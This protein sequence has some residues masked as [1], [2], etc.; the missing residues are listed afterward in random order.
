MHSQNKGT[1]ILKIRNLKKESLD[2]EVEGKWYRLTGQLAQDGF[3]ASKT[4]ISFISD[5]KH[6]IPMEERRK[7]AKDIAEKP[8]CT[9]QEYV[10]F[11]LNPNVNLSTNLCPISVVEKTKVLRVIQEQ[12]NEADAGF[13][14]RF[15]AP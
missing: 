10:D 3:H 15:D 9:S 7:L 8:Y 14:I 12:W 4:E 13:G 5:E 2:I 1:C 6:P 11:L